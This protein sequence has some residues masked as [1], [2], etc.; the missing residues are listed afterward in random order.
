MMPPGLANPLGIGEFT[1][2]IEYL[3]SLKNVGG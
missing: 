3:V 1:D 2:L